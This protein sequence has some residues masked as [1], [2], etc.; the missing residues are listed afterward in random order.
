M[1]KNVRET[2]AESTEIYSEYTHMNAHT[3]THTHTHMNAEMPPLSAYTTRDYMN[4]RRDFKI[5][6]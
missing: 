5:Y 3:H 2:D 4:V 1:E 6:L